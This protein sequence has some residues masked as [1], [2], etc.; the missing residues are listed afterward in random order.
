MPH[1]PLH[2]GWIEVVVGPMFSGKSEELIRRVKRALIGGQRVMVFKPHL[3]DRY[4]ASDVVSHDGKRIE[5]L[6]VADSAELRQNLPDPLPEVVAVDEAQFFDPGLVPLL[7]ELA[8][9]GVRVMVGGLDMDFRAEPFGIMP[10]L[11]ARAE[12]VEKLTAVCPVCGAPATR[13][14]RLVNG[15]PA[16]FDDPVILVGAQETYEPRCRKCHVVV[17]EPALKEGALG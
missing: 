9:K 14:Q 5:A 17:R 8:Q 3:D 1:L 6:S 15:Q 2:A 16:R 11:L 7:L 12:Y 4:H 10:E 13:T